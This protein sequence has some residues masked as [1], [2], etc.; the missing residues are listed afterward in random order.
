MNQCGDQ[1]QTARSL[2]KD[3]THTMADEKPRNSRK[4]STPRTPRAPRKRSGQTSADAASGDA[5]T[6]GVDVHS[7][8][9]PVLAIEHSTE[10]DGPAH[11]DVEEIRRQAYALY[12]SRGAGDGNDVSDWLEAE[13]IVR[14]HRDARGREATADGGRR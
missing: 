9:T 7:G 14:R 4:P 5:R 12:L 1:N 10:I 11:D 13:R 8:E 3:E 2:A 6:G